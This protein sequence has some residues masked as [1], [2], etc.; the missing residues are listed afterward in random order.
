MKIYV[1]WTAEQFILNQ[2]FALSKP[3]Y[4]EQDVAT[5]IS[6]VLQEENATFKTYCEVISKGQLRLLKAIAREKKV[7][8]PYESNFMR[9]YALT[10]PSSVKLALS[11]LIDKTLILKGDDGS[12]Y[13]YDRFFS[14][15]LAK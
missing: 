8:E 13:V 3:E 4:T 10:A 14:L 1:G 12:F 9:K 15:W 11:A 6:D 7:L 5:I 2:L